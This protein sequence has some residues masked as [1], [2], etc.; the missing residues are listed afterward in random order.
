MN[1]PNLHDGHPIVGTALIPLAPNDYKVEF[2][3]EE[4]D[5]PVNMIVELR[6]GSIAAQAS[7]SAVGHY[8]LY[9]YGV[10]PATLGAAVPVLGL[11]CTQASTGVARVTN[12][13][14]RRI[15]YS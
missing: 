15:L 2:D 3:I 5:D 1:V 11:V 4:N 10:N 8:V 9:M 13:S 14:M 7:P 6:V 12:I